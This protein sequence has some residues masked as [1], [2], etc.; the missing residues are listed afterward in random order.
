M[1]HQFKAWGLF[2]RRELCYAIEATPCWGH[3]FPEFAMIAKRK[4]DLP[5]NKEFKKA[6][7][8]RLPIIITVKERRKA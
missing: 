8:K 6:G 4:K 2:F 1:K 3:S 7:Y 5:F